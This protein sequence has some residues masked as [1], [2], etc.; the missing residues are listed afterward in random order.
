MSIYISNIKAVKAKTTAKTQH[1]A[2]VSDEPSCA[3]PT[4]LS[5][6]KAPIKLTP[7]ET[8]T[9]EWCAQGKTSWEIAKIV[10]CQPTTINFHMENIRRKFDVTTRSQAVLKAWK[11]NL[12]SLYELA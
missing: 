1:R 3:N 12:I 7:K 5:K 8:I 2:S 6:V 11:L 10:G 9:L 4:T